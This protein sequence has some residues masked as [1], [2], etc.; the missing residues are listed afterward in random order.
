MDKEFIIRAAKDFNINKK[1]EQEDAIIIMTEYCLEH[2]KPKDKIQEL[3]SALCSVPFLL[4]EYYTKAL[5]YY[6]DKYK[7]TELYHNNKLI[8]IY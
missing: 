2:N 4:S 3:I 7:I 6:L 1:I 5:N 8:N